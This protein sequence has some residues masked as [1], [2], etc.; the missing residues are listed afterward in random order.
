[1]GHDMDLLR[2]RTRLAVRLVLDTA[3][4]PRS[5]RA[6][7]A[8]VTSRHLLYELDQLCLDLR[9]DSADRDSHLVLVGQLTDRFDPL[10][11]MSGVP[12]LLTAGGNVLALTAS[13]RQG[14]FRILYEPRDTL[15]L[16]LPVGEGHLIEV[17]AP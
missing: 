2:G 9:L 4:H 17:P 15:A 3:D 11:P 16:C 6:R 5:A 8:G 7:G 14:E 12:V 13:D 1:M 10:K